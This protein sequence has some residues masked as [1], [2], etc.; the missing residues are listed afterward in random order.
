MGHSCYLLQQVLLLVQA[1]N[2]LCC[3][4]ENSNDALGRL[5]PNTIVEACQP[6][7]QPRLETGVQL[8]R[9]IDIS[10]N[11]T[12]FFSF[13]RFWFQFQSQRFSTNLLATL[14]ITSWVRTKIN[15]SQKKILLCLIWQA[16]GTW[17]GLLRTQTNGPCRAQIGHGL[18]YQS[19]SHLMH[20]LC[21]ESKSII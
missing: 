10:R 14:A 7:Q 1:Q 19:P 20:G 15:L 13:D 4:V 2:T 9:N 21:R 3:D 6:G 17:L 18:I 11:S 5:S 16:R 12:W 8:A